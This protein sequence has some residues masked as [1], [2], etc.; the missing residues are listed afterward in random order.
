ME[1]QTWYVLEDG[2]C[3]DP[4]EVAPD[5][6][7]VLR[8]KDGRAVAYA[9]HGPRTR[10]VNPTEARKAKPKAPAARD[11]KAD[12]RKPTYTTRESKAE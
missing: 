3:G 6:K 12:D 7:G 10:Q 5:K 8:H 4:A 1:M 9:E 11:M 2:T